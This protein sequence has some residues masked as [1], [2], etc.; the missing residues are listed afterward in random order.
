MEDIYLK[1]VLSDDDFVSEDSEYAFPL[2][3]RENG[4]IAIWHLDS[5]PHMLIAGAIGSGKTNFVKALL[6]SLCTNCDE[7]GVRLI[8]YNSKFVEYTRFSNKQHM[9]I[10][11]ITDSQKLESVFSWLLLETQKRMS[12]L[13]NEGSESFP[14]II[15]VID[16][17]DAFFATAETQ[18]NLVQLLEKGRIVKIHFI[19]VSSSPS[20]RNLASEIKAKIP[21]RISFYVTSKNASKMILDMGGAETLSYPGELIAKFQNKF[22]RG[23]G[24]VLTDEDEVELLSR[25]KDHAVLSDPSDHYDQILPG[26]DRCGDDDTQEELLDDLLLLAGDIVMETRNA[27]VSM[28]QRRMKLGYSRAA[29]IIDQ[30]ESIGVVGPFEGSKPRSVL[31]SKEQWECYKTDYN[32]SLNKKPVLDESSTLKN[33]YISVSETS[34]RKTVIDF[35]LELDNGRRIYHSHNKLCFC[36]R[37]TYL[38]KSATATCSIDPSKIEELHLKLPGLFRNGILTV[39]LSNDFQWDAHAGQNLFIDQN[40]NVVYPFTKNDAKALR[41]MVNELSQELDIPVTESH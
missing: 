27:S 12:L 30:L 1:T 19:F 13:V 37:T 20:S 34:I 10:P 22:E 38:G 18:R 14:H 16:D 4:S 8:I 36:E 6:V 39:V 26:R 17:Y 25:I 29:R 41:G 21:C 15:V 23:K 11:I 5:I 7:N 3:Y 33:S 24:F 32:H 31:I 28:L 40:G 35:R 9:L 2:V